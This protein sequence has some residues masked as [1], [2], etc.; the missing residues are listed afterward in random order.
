[1]DLKSLDKKK[2][3]LVVGIAIITLFVIVVIW[4][5]WMRTQNLPL[6]HDQ[7]TGK[8]LSSDIDPFY[9]LRIAETMLLGPLPAFDNMRY[10]ALQ[11]PWT[12]ELL[13]SVIVLIY[14]I[15]NVFGNLPIELAGILYPVI[16]F[17]LGLIAYFIFIYLL[18]KSK[19]TALISSILLAFI[20]I[21]LYRTMAG[22]GDHEPLGTFWFFVA[23]ILYLLIFS[24][25]NKKDNDKKSWIILTVFTLLFAVS[26]FLTLFGWPGISGYLLM[27]T[28][29][30]FAV[31]WLIKLQR[32]HKEEI[33]R[34]DKMTTI[35]LFGF[36]A[37]WIIFTSIILIFYGLTP[38][39][40]LD[41]LFF[42]TYGIFVIAVLIFVIVDGLIIFLS[43]S[44]NLL[45]FRKTLGIVSI[46]GLTILSIF[47]LLWLLTNW[48]LFFSL[49]TKLLK[50][51][52]PFQLERVGST[53]AE[54]SQPYIADLISQTGNVFFW[55]FVLG[56]VIFGVEFSK[57]IKTRK[58]KIIYSVLWIFMVFCV[59]LTRYSANSVF[60]GSGIFSV[61]VYLL[62]LLLFVAG[63]V[64]IYF[65]DEIEV[66]TSAIVIF[67]WAL[68]ILISVRASVRIFFV[69]APFICFAAGSAVVKLFDYARHN[70]D[71]TFR[72]LL[73][74]GV[75]IVSIG[76]IF[77]GWTFINSSTSQAK[78][79]G[80]AADIQ[81]QNS[82]NWTK[83]N[84]PN[85]SVFVHWWD[86][87]FW[88]QTLGERPTVT[89]GA[90]LNSYWD[91]LIGRYVLTTPKPETALSYMKS[92]NVSY[93]L[94]DPSDIGKYPAYSSIGSDNNSD[95][96]D[97][98]SVFLLDDK[99]TQETGNATYYVMTGGAPVMD[100][101]IINN[102]LLAKEKTGIGAFILTVDSA[103][104][105]K[106]ESILVSSG[107]QVRADIGCVAYNGQVQYF[108]N[109]SLD[110]CLYIIPSVTSSNINN[111]GAAIWLDKRTFNSLFAQLY[112]FNG[113]LLPSQYQ[114]AFNLAHS[115]ND[116][117]VTYIK[118]QQSFAGNIIYYYGLRAPLQIWKIN[119]PSNIIA[120]PE[121]LRTSGE[122][123]EFDNLSFTN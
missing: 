79:I 98:M 93:L 13:P 89:D 24:I 28:A 12:Q 47:T 113:K 104:I 31:L 91:H 21:F 84:T 19:V 110:G 118:S 112:L 56:T 26:T 59:L 80:P 54:N 90:H 60:N 23:L 65:N 99:Q 116:P 50:L 10:Q 1:M 107:L 63:F 87:G 20:P 115:E 16:F 88:V 102:H 108:N 22:V 100:D 43:N 29:F 74:F 51:I 18:G 5:S 72:L 62:G 77:S 4:S 111:L 46:A 33:T 38:G 53:V 30:S 66:N 94:L 82:M 120:R 68:F 81:W 57:N 14:K 121:F 64:W 7:T 52:H 106:V 76:L 97:Q 86:Y 8:W 39:Q 119:Y 42:N 9:W 25:L 117:A 70:K 114:N 103:G 55:I 15:G 67:S 11:S 2:V 6:L 122:Y 37:M 73:W 35:K 92:N 3:N 17:A 109:Y 78:M 123:G 58:N 41:K 40:A 27:M 85:G 44:R 32:L 95:R 71:E 34:E 48:E 49:G 101:I 45:K 96:Y 69:I 83:N 105:N 61:F 75:I 36:Y